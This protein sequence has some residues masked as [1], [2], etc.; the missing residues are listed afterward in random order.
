MYQPLDG[1]HDAQPISVFCNSGPTRGAEL[2][3]L[4]VKAIICLEQCGIK[5]HGVVSDGANKNRNVWSLFGVS[6]DTKTYFEHPLDE[7]RKIFVFSDTPHLLKTIRN[8][9]EKYNLRV[10]LKNYQLKLFKNYML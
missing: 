10:S 5:I 8:R 6:G 1:S 4:I 9:L 3:K 7:N 2:S